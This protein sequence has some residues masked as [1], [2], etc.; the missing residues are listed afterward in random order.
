MEAEADSDEVE[1]VVLCRAEGGRGWSRGQEIADGGVGVEVREA[2]VVDRDHVLGE[3]EA[4]ELGRVA[5]EDG[6]YGARAAGVVEDADGGG[7]G[8]VGWGCFEGGAWVEEGHADPV[9]V[10]EEEGVD[11]VDHVFLPWGACVRGCGFAGKGLVEG[12]DGALVVDLLPVLPVS[13]CEGHLLVVLIVRVL[14]VLIR[15]VV[16]LMKA[17][18]LLR[19]D[20]SD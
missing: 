17:T 2:G 15:A 9:E 6:G 8:G 16:M 14:V 7:G 10:R 19:H 20:C 5:G 18:F 3:V 12:D 1:G 11:F 13:L 4:H